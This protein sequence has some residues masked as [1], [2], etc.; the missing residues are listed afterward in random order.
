[1]SGLEILGAV[2]SSI[3]IVEV[4][5][6]LGKQ[7]IALKRLCD[8]V[9]DIP[10]TLQDHVDH[11][12]RLVPILDRMENEF[13]KAPSLL[14]EGSFAQQ[15]FDCCR[16]AASNLEGLVKGLQLQVDAVKK[17]NMKQRI[18]KFKVKL[19]KDLVD[20]LERKLEKD[21]RLLTIAHTTYQT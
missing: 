4:V 18:V 21:L 8:E 12:E 5:G 6:K 1:M 3:A 19:K 7:A 11:L 14:K 16:L 20:D 13:A 9:E 15:S 2:A 17:K 10:Q